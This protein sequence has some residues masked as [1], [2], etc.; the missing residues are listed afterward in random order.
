MVF[1][2]MAKIYTPIGLKQIGQYC[3]NRDH[4]TV[5]HGQQAASDMEDTDKHMRA[6]I[7]DIRRKLDDAVIS[8]SNLQEPYRP[9]EKFRLTA[10]YL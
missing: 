10:G 3:G 4:S 9:K 7:A 6:K 1:M 5:I 8:H 2:Y